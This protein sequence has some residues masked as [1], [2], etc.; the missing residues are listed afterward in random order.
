MGAGETGV[1]VRGGGGVL[2][3][4]RLLGD[5]EVKLIF[6]ALVWKE[7]GNIHIPYDCIQIVTSSAAGECAEGT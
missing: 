5:G 4:P 1:G 3:G 7:K 6:W 2:A